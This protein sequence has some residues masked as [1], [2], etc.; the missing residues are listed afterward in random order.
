MSAIA[1]DQEDDNQLFSVLTESRDSQSSGDDHIPT[2]QNIPQQDQST[3]N[4]SFWPHTISPSNQ[5]SPAAHLDE[6]VD[7]S[8]SRP[9]QRISGCPQQDGMGRDAFATLEESSALEPEVN[10]LTLDPP[11]PSK[12]PKKKRKRVPDSQEVI[13]PPQHDL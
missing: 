12:K 8:S 9:S 1:P 5:S 13:P 2:N 10:I 6:S 7:I 3:E 11:A 4:H